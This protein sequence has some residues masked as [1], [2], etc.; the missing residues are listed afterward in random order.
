MKRI[1]VNTTWQEDDDARR[2]FFAGLSYGERLRYYFELREMTNFHQ[3]QLP[4]KKNL[5]FII[6]LRKPT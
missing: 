2:K 5:G 6:L 3:P 4:K 1:K